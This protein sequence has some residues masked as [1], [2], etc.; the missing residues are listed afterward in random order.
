[1]TQNSTN[2][3]FH[4]VQIVGILPYGKAIAILY[5]VNAYISNVPFTKNYFF[6]V[7]WQIFT[8]VTEVFPYTFLDMT[9]AFSFVDSFAVKGICR[10]YRGMSRRVTI[11]DKCC[12]AKVSFFDRVMKNVKRTTCLHRRRRSSMID[13]TFM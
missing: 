9:N 8:Q 3:F 6:A 5:V 2:I 11:T 1:M 13:I 10:Y 12:V 4:L 7:F